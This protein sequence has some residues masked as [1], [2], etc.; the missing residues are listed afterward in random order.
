MPTFE[1]LL[2]LLAN[3]LVLATIFISIKN[4]LL[5]LN[6]QLFCILANILAYISDYPKGKE[7]VFLYIDIVK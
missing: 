5:T 4:L 2:L 6:R 3:L 7:C 1:F